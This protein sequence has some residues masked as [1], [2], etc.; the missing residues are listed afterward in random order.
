VTAPPTAGRRVV[1]TGPHAAAEVARRRDPADVVLDLDALHDALG[2][3]PG[4]GRV[5]AL[6]ALQAARQRAERLREHPAVWLVHPDAT[7]AQLATYRA[8]G[9]AVRGDA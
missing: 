2:A 3:V 4:P 5:V 1:V 8:S 9:W 6:A 7:P